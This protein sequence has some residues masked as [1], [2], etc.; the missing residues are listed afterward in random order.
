MP[1]Q[2]RLTPQEAR[3]ERAKAERARC[4]E[5]FAVSD[6]EFM[7]GALEA[8]EAS[9]RGEGKSLEEVRREYGL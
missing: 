6:K 3:F 8:L 2:R 9:E 5:S 4:I 1:S 7:K